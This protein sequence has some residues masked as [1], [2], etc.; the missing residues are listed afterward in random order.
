MGR[1]LTPWAAQTAFVMAC[2]YTNI[3]IFSH[4]SE[5]GLAA[6]PGNT[7]KG[8]MALRREEA[9]PLRVAIPS[10]RGNRTG[11]CVVHPCL[12]LAPLRNNWGNP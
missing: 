4:T 11:C 1:V 6:Q 8:G 7:A 9:I 2:I 5:A 12:D 10:A 3:G